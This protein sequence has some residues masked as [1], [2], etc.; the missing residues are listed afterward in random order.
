MP[1]ATDA[2]IIS[3]F[4]AR[5]QKA[6]SET[7]QKYGGLCHSIAK[8][9]LGSH[10]DAEECLNDA[11][12]RLWES[13]PPAKPN[14]LAAYLSVTVRNLACNRREASRAAKRGGGELTVALSEIEEV[15]A[16]PERPDTAL[17]TRAISEAIN[18]F[19]GEL[20]PE[21]RV[22]FVLR[23]W[24][25]LTVRE[26]AEKCGVGQSKVKMSLLRTRNDLKAFLE[27]EGLR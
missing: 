27:E 24:G 17:D 9:I 22:M 7:Q 21:T 11:L 2:Q 14:N 6:L 16:S 20:Q 1:A 25:D 3:L 19:L 10:E 5:D 12:L 18:R 15:L 26:I 8:N 13:I 23:Y 4:H